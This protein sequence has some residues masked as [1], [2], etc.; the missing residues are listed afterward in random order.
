NV[1]SVRG[2]YAQ[3]EAS[4]REALEKDRRL[5]GPSHPNT[6]SVLYNL[7]CMS[8]LSGRPAAALDWLGQAVQAGWSRGDQL[9]QDEDLES[10][11]GNPA[12]TALV[13]RARENAGPP[14][15][16]AE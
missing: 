11:R 13:A 6:L 9:A 8:A 2:P 3:A 15:R 1:T 7:G 16:A 10:L 12:F 4:L 14:G 5:F